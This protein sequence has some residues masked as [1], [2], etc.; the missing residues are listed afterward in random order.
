MTQYSSN[1]FIYRM[2]SLGLYNN[3]DYVMEAVQNY[4]HA[5]LADC[6]LDI[7]FLNTSLRL[8]CDW[9]NPED[10]DDGTVSQ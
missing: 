6:T 1:A 7:L 5:H 3:P 2:A 10:R 4:P 9:L 8:C